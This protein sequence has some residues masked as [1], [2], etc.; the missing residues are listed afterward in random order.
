[1]EEAIATLS[2][3]VAEALAEAHTPGDE[4]RPDALLAEVLVD[5]DPLTA[6][7]DM[8]RGS[9]YF[10]TARQLVSYLKLCQTTRKR[11]SDEERSRLVALLRWVVREFG[12]W[13]LDADPKRHRLVALFVITRCC[14]YGDNL[15]TRFPAGFEANEK[16]LDE[17]ARIIAGARI[18]VATDEFSRSP[19]SDGET[20]ER[21]KVAD[22]AGDWATICNEWRQ[23]RDHAFFY[24]RAL[25][26]EAI[27]CLFRFG[28]QRLLTALAGLRQIVLAYQYLVTLTIEQSF[29]MVLASSNPY[30]HFGAVLASLPREREI[31]LKPGE[32]DLLTD[33][34][35]KIALDQA[36]WGRWMEALNRYPIRHPTIQAALGRALAQVAG[37]A[38]YSYVNAISLS[39]HS[40][41]SREVVAGCLREFRLRAD[42]P[43]RQLLWRLAHDRW[44]QW[45]F[46]AAHKT[47]QEL[48]Q[49]GCSELDYAIVGY[50]TECISEEERLSIR[51]RIADSLSKLPDVW[52]TSSSGFSDEAY[53][54]L[55]A[56]QVYGYAE[57]I[58]PADDWLMETNRRVLP[59][60]PAIHRYQAILYRMAT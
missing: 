43:R 52:H 35:L 12:Q 25:Y 27:P 57:T 36:Q 24:R 26:L 5:A 7:S 23:Y 48:H 10:S 21:F 31:P 47:Q 44:L 16:V 18:G 17:L 9:A 42:L 37:D 56:Y 38:L 40:R 51:E 3:Y 39:A 55:S 53:R 32:E 60:D 20:I 1:M 29:T 59:F 45:N 28:Y 6:L 8:E 58:G 33:L 15:W 13:R 11:P 19:I 14:N 46:D 30:L 4:F 41:G 22:A 2:D 49:M 34:F 54:L 50:A